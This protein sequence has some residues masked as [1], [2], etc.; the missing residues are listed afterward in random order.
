[1]PENQI[2]IYSKGEYPADVLSNFYPNSF[3]IDGVFC[4]AMEGFLQSLKYR[5]AAKQRSVCALSGKEAKKAGR[6]K[7]LWKLTGKVFWQGR[8]IRRD[9]EEF[10]FLIERAYDELYKNQ[11]FREAL[12]HSVGK[13]L[14]HSIGKTDKRATILTTEEFIGN[15]DRLRSVMEK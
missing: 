3:E 15:L 13:T 8:K 6:R 5:S 10:E 7:F 14:L 1:M 11:F 9:S 2:D 4:A 12:K